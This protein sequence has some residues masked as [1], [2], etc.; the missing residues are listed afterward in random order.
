MKQCVKFGTRCGSVNLET[1][2]AAWTGPTFDST[3]QKISAAAAH[4]CGKRATPPEANPRALEHLGR[5]RSMFAL[6]Q[7]HNGSQ[8]SSA[9]RPD[10]IGRQH[11]RNLCISAA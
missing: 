8:K 10:L 3:A 9:V 4:P 11:G 6:L 1:R 5:G 7:C 2:R